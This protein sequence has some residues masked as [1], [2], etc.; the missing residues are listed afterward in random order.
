MYTP[1][2][3]KNEQDTG[4][5]SADI[6]QL[7][8]L[9]IDRLSEKL[10]VLDVWLVCW[11]QLENRRDMLSYR[12]NNGSDDQLK[13]Y[14]ESERWISENL[15][16]LELTPLS[17]SSSDSQAYVCGLG[18]TD[19]HWDYLLLWTKQHIS[20]FQRDLVKDY[21]QLLQKYLTLYQEN[22]RQ[23]AKIQ[24]LEQA[25]QQAEHQLRN[26]LSLISLYAENI[27]LGAENDTQKQ[28]AYCISQAAREISSNLGDLLNCGKQAGMRRHR[29]DLLA[30]LQNVVSLLKPVLDAKQL[31]IVQSTQPVSLIVDGWQIEQVL[32]NLLDNAIHYSPVGGTIAVDWQVSQ[33]AVLITVSDQGPGIDGLDVDDLFAPFFSQRPQGTGLG[34]AIAKKIILDH[35][36]SIAAETLSQGGAK[37]SIFLPR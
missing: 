4:I 15:P 22:L 25:L 2:P 1:P 14:L 12:R 28:Q 35:Q 33:Q 10:P 34:L 24:L 8:Q 21:A 31:T 9:Q 13:S 7:C 32:Q 11:N 20:H 17:I 23:R 3:S 27:G 29:H 5:S 16:F 18:K 26:P 37:F 30:L 6:R 36:G 19:A